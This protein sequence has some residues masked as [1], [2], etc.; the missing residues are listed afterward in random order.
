MGDLAKLGP[1]N[2]STGDRA[3]TD[4]LGKKEDDVNVSNL[5]ESTIANGR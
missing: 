2:A 3:L 5:A 1:E 4:L